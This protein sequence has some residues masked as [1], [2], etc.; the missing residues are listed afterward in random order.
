[1]LFDL[2]RALLAALVVAVAP[3]WFWARLLL[4]SED[5]V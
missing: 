2:I 3:G 1:V 5:R 4:A